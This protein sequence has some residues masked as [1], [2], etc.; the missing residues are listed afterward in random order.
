MAA[1][2]LMRH[3]GVCYRTAWRTKHKIIKGMT[4]RE[5]RRQLDG[6][7]TMDDAYLGGA[8]NGGKAG[9]GSKNKVPFVIAL[10]LS[11]AG[12][13]KQGVMTP[14]PGFTLKVLAT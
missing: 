4:E 8:R 3:L 13:P 1:L 11:D 12:H 5:A 2:E 9:R 7:V 10:E 6:I 14:V